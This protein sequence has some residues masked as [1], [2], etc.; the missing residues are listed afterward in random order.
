VAQGFPARLT[1]AD[2]GRNG[3]F[4][5]PI[6]NHRVVIANHAARLRGFLRQHFFKLEAVFFNVLVYSE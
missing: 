4:R 6:S 1:I 3:V 5:N 2:V